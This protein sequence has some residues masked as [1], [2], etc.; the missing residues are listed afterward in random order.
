MT[1]AAAP[2]L[3]AYAALGAAALMTALVTGSPELAVLAAP[4]VL[5]VAVA[6]AAAPPA[7]E[8]KLRL[9]RDRALEG[10]AVLA[11]LA[12]AN[13][14]ASGRVTVHL[15]VGV[16]LDADPTP[17][18]FWLGRG[19]RRDLRFGVSARHWGV[20]AVGPAIVRASDRLGALTLDGPLGE[21]SELRVYAGAERL[22]RI[23]EPQRTRPVLGSHVSRELGEGI[24]FADL[25]PLAPGDR[26]RSINWRATARRRTPY[27]NIRH[28]EHSADVVLFLDTFAEARLG[29]EGTLDA[30]VRAAARLAATYLARRDRVALVSLGGTLTWLTGSAGT[31]HLYR[32]LDALFSS[33]VRPSFRWK[34]VSQMPRR[35]VPAR[36]LVIA[37]SPLLDERG[38]AALLDLRARGYDLVVVEISPLAPADAESRAPAVRLWRLYREALRARFEALGIPVAYWEPTGA[39]IEITVQEVMSRRRR[40]RPARV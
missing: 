37:L 5:F 24:E 33:E 3:R 2:R 28:P 16:R 27:V 14:G 25:R 38:I 7:L 11:T 18:A 1:G 10:E 17:V 13:S 34:A 12:I 4:F 36:A 35:P 9:H 20:H 15:P 19:E 30:A 21:S 31:G 23:V 29:D 39:G 26:V 32:I 22:R 8:G 6:L 40:A